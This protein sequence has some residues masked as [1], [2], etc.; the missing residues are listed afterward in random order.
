M[1]QL[2]TDLQNCNSPS[3][4]QEIVLRALESGANPSELREML[5]FLESCGQPALKTRS[6]M[7]SERSRVVNPA[8]GSWATFL[9][10]L[11]YR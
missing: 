1:D 4:R 2:F 10:S 8:K 5:D 9:S 7:R 11:I 3:E 6:L